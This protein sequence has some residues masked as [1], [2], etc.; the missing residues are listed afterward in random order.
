MKTKD[1]YAALD[2][3][4]GFSAISVVLYHLGHWLHYPGLATNSYLAVDFFFC[5]SGFVLPFAYEKR[6][7]TDMTPLQFWRIRLVR[8]MPL[9]A[10]ATILSALYVAARSAAHIKIVTYD[11]LSLAAVLGV[12]N[13]PFL[14]ASFD[15]G[16]PQIFPLNGP[17]FSLFLELIVNAVWSMLSRSLGP[18]FS[19]IIC[20]ASIGGLAVVGIGGD[21]TATFWSGF[22]RVGASFFL[23]V[24]IYR[25]QAKILPRASLRAVFFVSTAMMIAAFY[26]PNKLPH[27]VELGWILLVSPLVVISAA[28]T[29]LTEPW[30]S[31]ALLAGALSYPIYVLHYPIFCW[32]NGIYQFGNLPQ[33]ALIEYPLLVAGIIF[34][35]FVL[36]RYFDEPVRAV[37]GRATGSRQGTRSERPPN[38]S[39]LPPRTEPR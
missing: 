32:L 29:Q 31:L 14:W 20:F 11:E 17:Q 6:L 13:V 22:P 38:A 25:Y 39:D 19:L 1:H 3:L 36:L 10:L 33:K 5:L 27:L 15:I 16:G 26:Y 34:T 8:L 2:A 30:Q 18:L 9:V 24:L 37:L 7:A 28:R 35:S 23:G 12:L 4:R 21:E